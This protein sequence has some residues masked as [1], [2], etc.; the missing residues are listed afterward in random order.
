MCRMSSRATSPTRRSS[1]DPGTGGLRD[2]S[3]QP[4]RPEPGNGPRSRNRR[5]R[6]KSRCQATTAL[7]CE[8]FLHAEGQRSGMSGPREPCLPE[9]AFCRTG[10]GCCRFGSL[11]PILRRVSSNG[12]PRPRT[13]LHTRRRILRPW[14]PC[15]GASTR[16][17]RVHRL[18]NRRLPG[19]I[20][21][22]GLRS[23]R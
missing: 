7:S 15:S 2:L 9:Q 13:P 16:R 22:R 1:T 12:S 14:F 11:N 19:R 23:D 4:R 10:R 8:L 18:S 21:V 3:R 5:S 17:R 20:R 6:R